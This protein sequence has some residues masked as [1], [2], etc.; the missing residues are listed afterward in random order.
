[1]ND[2]VIY[3]GP[4]ETK[5]P[6]N[7]KP[8]TPV[9]DKPVTPVEPVAPKAPVVEKESVLPHTG[10]KSTVLAMVSGIVLFVLGVFGFKSKEEN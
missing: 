7:P 3:F 6:E 10:E 2:D 1:M 5:T 8:V 4:V 9:K